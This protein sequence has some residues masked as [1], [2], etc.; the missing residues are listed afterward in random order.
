MKPTPTIVLLGTSLFVTGVEACLRETS[1]FDVQRLNPTAAAIRE[2]LQALH[3][4]VIVF[5]SSESTPALL[6]NLTQLLKESLDIPVIGLDLATNTAVTIFSAHQQEI[7]KAD[8]LADTI[9]LLMRPARHW[10]EP[11]RKMKGGT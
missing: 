6:P 9:R 3:P 5:D 1:Q 7:L 11:E 2:E 10:T 8:D 4:D